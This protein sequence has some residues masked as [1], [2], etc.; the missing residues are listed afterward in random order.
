MKKALVNY[1]QNPKNDEYYTP[2]YGIIPLAEF[3]P[4]DKIIW[5]C[6]DYGESKITSFFRDRGNKVI[7]TSI[8]D[9]E[10]FLQHVPKEEYDIIITNPPYS[11]KDEFLKRAYELKKPFA[12]LLPLESLG[13]KGR[14]ELYSNYGLEILVVNERIEFKKDGQVWF[15]T[16]WFCHNILPEKLVFRKID[17]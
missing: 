9:N 6:T 16:G 7:T 11:I 5:E 14:F 17:K 2:T 15:P 3:I 4:I 1:I 10:N 8:K 13:G 12:F